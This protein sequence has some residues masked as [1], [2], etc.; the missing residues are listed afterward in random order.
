MHKNSINKFLLLF[1]V[2]LI[3]FFLTKNIYSDYKKNVINDKIIRWGKDWK[4]NK[5][6]YSGSEIKLSFRNSKTFSL[7][8]SSA[9]PESD[10]EI[11]I[12][13]GDKKYYISSPNISDKELTIHL[14]NN[15]Y[16]A[17][18]TATIKYFC[19]YQYYPCDITIE[20]ISLDNSA[21]LV[22]SQL[23]NKYIAVLGDSISSNFGS[24]NYTHFLADNLNLQLHNASIFLSTVTKNKNGRD[25]S[26]RLEKDI[27]Q[28]HPDF[29][30]IFI[31]VNDIFEK[32][33]INDFS[34]TYRGII[35]RIK[36]NSG[37]TK[38]IVVGILYTKNLDTS[39]VDNYNNAIKEIAKSENI[40]YINTSNWLT[41]DD[42][43]DAIHPSLQ[44]QDKLSKMLTNKLLLLKK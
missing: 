6:Q 36:N 21:S 33:S 22:N 1:L 39:L 3:T 19:V 13:I 16:N 7:K 35:T 34:N 14:P 29:V 32:T 26:T 8:A 5:S 23:P 15:S 18:Q 24:E 12:S 4:N 38:I 2:A 25:A 37:K 41:K 17:L 27:I 43:M 10:Q 20:S 40:A 44:S 28:F 31:G 11:E 30:L 9:I 42:Y